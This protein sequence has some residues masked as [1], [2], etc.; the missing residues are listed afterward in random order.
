MV[1]SRVQT[2]YFKSPHLWSVSPTQV[3]EFI[4]WS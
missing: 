3:Y 1:I 2:A 4:I